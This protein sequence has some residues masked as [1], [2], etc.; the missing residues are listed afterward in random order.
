[1]GRAEIINII[2]NEEAA[3][4]ARIK[5]VSWLPGQW[6]PCPDYQ[7]KQIK[8]FSNNILYTRAHKLI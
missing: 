3:G 2:L 4:R 1:M 5:W 6:G 7:C 8:R